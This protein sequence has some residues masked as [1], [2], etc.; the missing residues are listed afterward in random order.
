[1]SVT[2]VTRDAIVEQSVIQ[3]ACPKV[4]PLE[5]SVTPEM[6]T[7]MMLITSGIHCEY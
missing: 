1:M 5:L 2:F 4:K 6:A 7:A 3:N